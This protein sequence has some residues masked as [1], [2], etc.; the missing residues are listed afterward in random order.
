MTP[1]AVCFGSKDD[2]YGSFKIRVPGKI[3]TFKLAYLNGSLSCTKDMLSSKWG[4][5]VSFL[6]NH[7]MGTHITD[8][9]KRR[10]L[11]KAEHLI[12]RP[13]CLSDIY[14]NLPWATLD[15]PE[16]I[17]D[18]FI[19][20]LP[21]IENQEFQVWFGEDLIKCGHSDNGLE[22][23]CARVHGLYV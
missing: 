18:N 3:L 23:T 6:K 21:V 5:R 11:P 13:D 4:C 7:H 19:I 8:S 14:Y 15:S 2:S 22:K 16:L 9:S 12:G 17:F 10:I 1:S 20:P